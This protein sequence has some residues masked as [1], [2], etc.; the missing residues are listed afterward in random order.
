MFS[1]ANSFAIPN[2]REIFFE[3]TRIE[4]GLSMRDHYW[5]MTLEMISNNF[6][7]GIGPGSWGNFMFS[8]L[9]VMLESFEGQLL[10]YGYTIT[11]GVNAAHNIYLVF[12]SEMGIFGLIVLFIFISSIYYMTVKIIKGKK[13]IIH[14]KNI[15]TVGISAVATGMFIR[16]FFDSISLFTFGWISIDLPFWFLIIILSYTYKNEATHLKGKNQKVI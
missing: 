5:N 9:P 2:F 16:G 12:F 10:L 3:L 14:S 4:A 15:L 13:N 7:I 6:L 8:Y 1:Y 11:Q